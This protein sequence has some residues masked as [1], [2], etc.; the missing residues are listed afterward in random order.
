MLKREKFAVSLRQEKRKAIICSKRKKT[1]AALGRNVAQSA[2]QK[3]SDYWIPERLL[4][5]VGMSEAIANLHQLLINGSHNAYLLE[6][7]QGMRNATAL[8]NPEN[9]AS[10][11]V[12]LTH[13][14]SLS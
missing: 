9:A 4:S 11:W 14:D 10:S 5:E 13:P 1:F 7:L 6:T 3:N 12:L 2:V 8:L